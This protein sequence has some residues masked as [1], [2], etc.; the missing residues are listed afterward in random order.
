MTKDSTIST[1]TILPPAVLPQLGEVEVVRPT[2]VVQAEPR[3]IALHTTDQIE[4]RRAELDGGP[5]SSVAGTGQNASLQVRL[6]QGEKKRTGV[7]T[8][9]LRPE[10]V[11]QNMPR[12]GKAAGAVVLS[13]VE[14]ARRM[15][16]EK[17]GDDGVA[18][19]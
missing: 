9:S 11:P 19:E 10:T 4:A 16:T 6:D 5:A 1:Q 18:K 13:L 12:L 7:R 15:R 17:A 3:P 8:K 2:E 14:D